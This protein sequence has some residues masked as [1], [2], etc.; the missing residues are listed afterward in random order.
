[1]VSLVHVHR[2]R[3]GGVFLG[4]SCLVVHNQYRERFRSQKDDS[5]MNG[6]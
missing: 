5:F 3:C 1:M 6:V 4:V 2:E